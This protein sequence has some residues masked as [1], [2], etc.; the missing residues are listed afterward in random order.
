MRRCQQSACPH[1]GLWQL[2][3]FLL[4]AGIIGIILDQ[5]VSQSECCHFL[6]SAPQTVGG[7]EDE[8]LG[9]WVIYFVLFERDLSNLVDESPTANPDREGLVLSLAVNDKDRQAVLGVA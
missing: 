3:A 8:P 5:P 7:S 6:V 1:L 9:I 2:G 4:L